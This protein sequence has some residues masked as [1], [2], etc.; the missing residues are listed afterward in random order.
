MALAFTDV[1]FTR[2]EVTVQWGPH[3]TERVGEKTMILSSV[4]V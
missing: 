3:S 1:E 4:Q 2:H